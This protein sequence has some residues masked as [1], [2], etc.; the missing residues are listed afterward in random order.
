M[1]V[2]DFKPLIHLY[3]SFDNRLTQFLSEINRPG[4]FLS[5]EMHKSDFNGLKLFYVL[6]GATNVFPWGPFPTIQ[7]KAESTLKYLPNEPN[8]SSVAQ[9]VQKL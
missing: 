1:I 5:A 8:P 6:L 9:S 3:L 2:D 4:G 7:K